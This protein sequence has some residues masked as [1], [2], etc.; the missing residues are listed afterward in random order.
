MFPTQGQ[1]PPMDINN[2]EIVMA[3]VVYNVTKIFVMPVEMALHP[4]Y[5]ST[6]CPPVILFFS[7][8]MMIL[9]PIFSALAGAA[10][11]LVPLLRFHPP[12]GMFGIGALSQLFFLGG[13]I[14]GLR[15]WRRMIHPERELISDWEG[16][17]LPIFT[18]L[19][20]ASWWT[21]RIVYEPLFLLIASS[22]LQD[23]YILQ[24]SAAHYLM[25]AAV[26]LAFNQYT[27]WYIS[28]RFLRT[29]MNTRNIGPII[30]RIID[31][32]ASDNDRAALHLASIPKDFPDDMR[33]ETAAHIARAFNVTQ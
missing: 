27:A 9:L 23:F 3:N 19:P 32:T 25:F 22:L 15:I 26:A 18:M 30:A 16:P 17:P 24:P 20:K 7:A 5:G 12:M 11:H 33:K 31:N 21:I 28:W 6:Y 2:L 29:A 4:F 13:F 10:A 14:H 1:Q 8:V